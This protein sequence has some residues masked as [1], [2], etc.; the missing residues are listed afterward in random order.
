MLEVM[1]IWATDRSKAGHREECQEG[2]ALCKFDRVVLNKQ[3][4]LE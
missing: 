3:V 2:M 1:V 4:T